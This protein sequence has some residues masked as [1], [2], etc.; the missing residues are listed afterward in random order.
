[1]TPP[2]ILVGTKFD[3]AVKAPELADQ[4][5]IRARELCH[6]FGGTKSLAVSAFSDD[7]VDQVFQTLFS[8]LVDAKIYNE[9]K[10]KPSQRKRTRSCFPKL[11]IY[12]HKG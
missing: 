3:L 12:H 10:Q 2:F 6:Q 8:A 7:S 5:Q 4:L 1:M 11:C 9:S